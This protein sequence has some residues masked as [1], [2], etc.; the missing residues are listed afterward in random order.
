MKIVILCGGQGTRL[1]E[2]TEFKPKPM[3][4]I[5]GKPIL[6][7][8]MKTYSY[9]GFNDFVLC[10][11][12][13]GEMI[14]QYFCNYEILNNDFSVELGQ[15]TLQLNTRH[16]EEG[17][18]ITFAETGEGS[19]TGSRVKQVQKYVGDETFMLTYGDGVTDLDIRSL[20][21]YHQS[22]GRTGTV[23]GVLPESRYGELIIEDDH[24]LAFDEKPVR[25]N[26]ISGGYFVFN[27]GI[28]GYLKE[29]ENCILEREALHHLAKDNQL[30]VFKHDGFWQC[31]DT[32]RD[33][34]YL[35]DLWE[36]G[37]PAW[38]KWQQKQ[39]VS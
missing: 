13:K 4:E 34:K 27:P 38:T 18:K 30:K 31:M 21:E 11:G 20:L 39:T 7:H 33:Y 22:H 14:K 17:W 29:D 5:G 25:K 26:L 36:K 2:E 8:I 15:G 28:F 1:R 24:V 16:A 6:W 37:N 10:L 23:T 12:Y 32:Y 3:V 9:Y 19:M 35:Q